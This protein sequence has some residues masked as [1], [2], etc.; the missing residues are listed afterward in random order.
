MLRLQHKRGA[1]ELSCVHYQ[2]Y[3]ESTDTLHC[4]GKELSVYVCCALK[5][6]ANIELILDSEMFGT[7]EDEV[8][9]FDHSEDS[10]NGRTL[11]FPL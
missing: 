5:G 4:M 11:K 2:E 9:Q 3:A 8:P 6:H 7:S 1:Q 10:E